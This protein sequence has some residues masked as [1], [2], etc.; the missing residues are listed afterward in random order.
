[1]AP[2][3]LDDVASLLERSEFHTRPIIT[4]TE[5]RTGLAELVDAITARFALPLEIVVRLPAGP[6]GAAALSWLYRSGEVLQ[7]DYGPRHTEVRV[8]CRHEDAE[9]VAAL[10]TVVSRTP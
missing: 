10:G 9:R 5:T 2:Q 7:V 8:R 6:E 4:S 3:R 1:V